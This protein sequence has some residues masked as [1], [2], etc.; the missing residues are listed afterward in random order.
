MLTKDTKDI[1]GHFRHTQHMLQK[2]KRLEDSH[3]A[4]IDAQSNKINTSAVLVSR[5]LGKCVLAKR[6]VQG[7]IQDIK[8]RTKA[9]ITHLE[10]EMAMF[11][12]PRLDI[13]DCQRKLTI[14]RLLESINSL[15]CVIMENTSCEIFSCPNSSGQ[16][17][18]CCG[19]NICSSCWNKITFEK[20]DMKVNE[21]D[22]NLLYN[23]TCAKACPFCRRLHFYKLESKSVIMESPSIVQSWD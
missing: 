12:D 10:K 7:H 9:Y 23:V 19:K 17:K 1:Q 15:K 16:P 21:N 2:R 11:E 8:T 5:T 18:S 13:D 3:K 6:T 14:N 22:E 20:L 4:N